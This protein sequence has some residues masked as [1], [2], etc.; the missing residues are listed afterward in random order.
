MPKMTLVEAV[1]D[2]MDTALAN[3]DDVV[4]LGEDI[5]VDGGVF[6]ATD[7]LLDEYGSDRVID[8]PLA[9]SGIV[10]SAIGLSLYGKTP[11]AEIQFSGFTYPALDQLISHASRFRTRTRG[12]YNCQMVV[13]TPYGGGVHAPEHHSES[14]E[15]LYAHTPGLKMVIPSGPYDAKGLLLAAIRDPDPVMFYEPKKIYRSFREDVPDEPY[16]VDIGSAKVVEEGSDVTLIS[17]G[18]MLHV[19]KDAAE[20][21]MEEDDVSCEVIDLRSIY[22]Y[23]KDT[24]LE[25]VKKTGKAVIVHEAPRTG[26]MGAEIA[27]MISDRDLL[28]LEAPVERVTGYDTIYPLY[29]LEAEYMPTVPKIRRAIDNVMNF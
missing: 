28:Y 15:A 9:E 17:W 18:A 23:D 3:D 13:R 22:P 19:A 5:G 27:A 26:G 4:L 29:K 10:G 12:R 14:M 8:T 21:A 20:Q 6:R 24:I 7:G 25:S 1:R 11:V 16:E 2:A